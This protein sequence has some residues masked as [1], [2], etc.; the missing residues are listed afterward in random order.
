MMI[1][2]LCVAVF[3]SHAALFLS[4]GTVNPLRGVG[5]KK[6]EAGLYCLRRAAALLLGGQGNSCKTASRAEHYRRCSASKR[7]DVPLFFYPSL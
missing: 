5:L 3:V 4:L 1:V 6:K 2:P 7:K